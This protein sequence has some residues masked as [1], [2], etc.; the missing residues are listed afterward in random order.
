MDA[1]A[2]VDVSETEESARR[3]HELRLIEAAASGLPIVMSD[4]GCAGELLKNEESALIVHP[5][6]VIG[7]TRAIERVLQDPELA[8]RIGARAKQVALALPGVEE[9]I[10]EMRRW[11]RS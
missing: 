9:G 2:E 1:I 3:S 6:D 10:E 11:L 8:E 7:I 5:G 4:V